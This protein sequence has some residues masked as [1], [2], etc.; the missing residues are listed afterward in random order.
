MITSETGWS[1]G[2]QSHSFQ[3]RGVLDLIGHS[4]KRIYG[5]PERDALPE[6]LRDLIGRLERAEREALNTSER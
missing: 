2:A 4:L 3:E 5:V 1:L 6:Q